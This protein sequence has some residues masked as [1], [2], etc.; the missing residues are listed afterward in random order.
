[1]DLDQIKLIEFK[2]EINEL[3]DEYLKCFNNGLD[4]KNSQKI[5]ST[6]INYYKRMKSVYENTHSD[7][8]DMILSD[9]IVL[10]D[11]ENYTNIMTD[12]TYSNNDKKHETDIRRRLLGLHND[13]SV[14][15]IGGNNLDDEFKNNTHYKRVQFMEDPFQN[16]WDSSVDPV[17]YNTKIP[18]NQNEE[19]NKTTKEYLPNQHIINNAKKTIIVFESLSNIEIIDNDITVDYDEPQI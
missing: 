17:T 14:G 16:N 12:C 11:E 5:L 9:D 7:S 3:I 2:Q 8:D 10:S 18:G 1:M 6:V 13:N 19:K 15:Y 4:N